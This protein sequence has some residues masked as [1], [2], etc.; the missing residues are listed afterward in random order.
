MTELKIIIKNSIFKKIWTHLSKRR[1]IQFYL[2]LILIIMSSLSEIISLGAVLPFLGALSS[3]DQLFQHPFAQP[4]IKFF[5]LNDS[6]QLI[7]VFT[8]FFIIAVLLACIIRLSLLFTMI[9][10]SNAVGLDFG[11]S[12]YRRTLYQKYSTHLQRNSSE[13]IDA[14]IVKMN[15]VIHKFLIPILMIISSVII[16]IGILTLIFLINTIV[17]LSVFVVFSSLYLIVFYNCRKQIKTDF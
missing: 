10:F 12:I 4:V 14:T 6:R 2:I 17:A 11:E 13:V 9:R 1:K 16:T 3:P 15:T 7:F 5:E 8:I